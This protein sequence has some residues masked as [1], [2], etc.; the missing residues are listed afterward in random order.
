MA[1]IEALNKFL[2]GFRVLGFILI[3]FFFWF[4]GSFR[5]RFGGTIKDLFFIVTFF[6]C[7]SCIRLVKNVNNGLVNSIGR[8]G[9][10]S[11]YTSCVFFVCCNCIPLM[12]LVVAIFFFPYPP[13]KRPLGRDFAVQRVTR[14]S[15]DVHW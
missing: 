12:V 10:P 2:F 7:A 1:H 14:L 8:V 3:F 15:K 5:L 6:F 11:R 13:L 9:D 4:S